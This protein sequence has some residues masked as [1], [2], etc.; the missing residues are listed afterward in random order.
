MLTDHQCMPFES[1]S[2]IVGKK[3]T[4]E[5]LCAVKEHEKARFSVIEDAV[6]T[7]SDVVTDRLR[8]LVGYE[9][10]SRREKNERNVTYEITTRGETVLEYL[11]EVEFVLNRGKQSTDFDR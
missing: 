2:T 4:I 11:Q 3:R 5:V 8:L 6:T 10:L 7:S 9:L 1:V